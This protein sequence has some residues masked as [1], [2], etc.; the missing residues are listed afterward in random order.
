MHSFVDNSHLITVKVY[1]FFL[2][3]FFPMLEH[4]LLFV[5]FNPGGGAHVT[6]IFNLNLDTFQKSV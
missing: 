2:P 6:N 4:I 1:E 5:I 3:Y